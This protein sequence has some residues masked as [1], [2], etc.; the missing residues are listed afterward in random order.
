MDSIAEI[1][2]KTGLSIY[3]TKNLLESLHTVLECSSLN[4]QNCSQALL[5]S[6]LTKNKFKNIEQSFSVLEDKI[7]RQFL[8]NKNN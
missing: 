5:L 3:E 4:N 6:K 7:Y 1:I 8:L 2:D